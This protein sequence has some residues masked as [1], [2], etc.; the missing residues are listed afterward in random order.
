LPGA[1]VYPLEAHSW[2]QN[3]NPTKEQTMTIKQIN[4]YIHLNGTAEKAIQLYESWMFNC[5]LAKA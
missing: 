3:L 4:P 2:R 1:G 5:E